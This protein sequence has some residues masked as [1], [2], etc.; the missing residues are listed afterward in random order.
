MDLLPSGDV[1]IDCRWRKQSY[2]AGQCVCPDLQLQWWYLS[3][4]IN[5]NGHLTAILVYKITDTVF[6]ITRSLCTDY[7][8]CR[9]C[10]RIRRSD[11]RPPCT[12]LFVH[13]AISTAVTKHKP[14]FNGICMK[15][16]TRYDGTATSVSEPR[17]NMATIGKVD[18]SDL[19]MI[20]RWFTNIY[21]ELPKHARF[22][23]HIQ[24]Y[25]LPRR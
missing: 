7:Q 24:T 8:M 1:L 11:H 21:S 13:T 18:T 4:I 9:I 3:I 5:F 15:Q 10:P 12:H 2:M 25:I 22:S 20:I 14:S 19:M 6:S 16:L 23:W 17:K